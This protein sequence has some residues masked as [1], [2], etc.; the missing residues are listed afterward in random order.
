MSNLLTYNNE[1][2]ELH[3]VYMSFRW[4]GIFWFLVIAAG[5]LGVKA[6]ASA[7]GDTSQW[8]QEKKK[9][10]PGDM[11]VPI[12]ATCAIAWAVV[13]LLLQ[14]PKLPTTDSGTLYSQPRQAQAA[15]A[16]MAGFGVAGYAVK[17]FIN[18]RYEIPAASTVVFSL[19]AAIYAGR[20][21]MHT[22]SINM[23]PTFFMS[24]ICA[25]LPVQTIA[26]GT[27]GI[28]IGYSIAVL[29]NHKKALTDEFEPI[30]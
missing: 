24:P 8:E 27:L 1:M 26:F 22:I 7:C 4:E 30:A 13:S 6:A 15:F 25:L 3:N 9:P 18:I 23:P 2:K 28:L 10:M 21:S 16:L 29:G 20:D 5:Y 19:A 12:L 14:S 11:I 17:R